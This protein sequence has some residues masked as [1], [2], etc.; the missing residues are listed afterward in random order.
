[1]VARIQRKGISD[2]VAE[3]AAAAE[4][5]LPV[6]SALTDLIDRDA[7]V[8]DSVMAA[9]RLP[10][11]SEAQAARRKQAFNAAM[12]DAAETQLETMRGC[13]AALRSALA[14]AQHGAR[15]AHGDV[16]MAIELLRAA[17]RGA[18]ANVAIDLAFI[19]DERYREEAAAERLRL[20]DGIQ[21]NAEAGLGALAHH[22]SD[23]FGRRA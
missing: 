18:S 5:L 16:G 14:V 21:A 11:A 9:T 23:G 10:A 8:Y 4:H 15:S 1:M 2:H 13:S 19:E 22:R 7:D 3:L 17:A 12:R 20:D 6:Q